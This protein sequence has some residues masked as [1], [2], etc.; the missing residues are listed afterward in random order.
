MTPQNMIVLFLTAICVYTDLRHGKIYNKL[1]YPAVVLGIAL[2]FFQSHPDPNQSAAGLVGALCLYGLLRKCSG[3]GAGDVKLMAAIGAIKGLPFIIFG[4]LY[5]F[6]FGCMAGL[7]VLAWNG[8][9]I[10]GIKWVA[11]TVASVVVP[12]R[13]RPVLEGEMTSMPFAP[14]IFLGVVY[15]VYL[16][17]IDGPFALLP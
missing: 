17:F 1:T 11:L 4:S 9:L 6:G 14:A 7:V 13:E 3:M 16:E 8:R 5:I 2:S 15:G 10:P 12:G